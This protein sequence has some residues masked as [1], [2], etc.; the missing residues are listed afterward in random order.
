MLIESKLYH[1]HYTYL[2]SV[3]HEHE[4]SIGSIDEYR[5]PILQAL[6]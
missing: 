1:L 2:L 6:S 4:S 5:I 3:M